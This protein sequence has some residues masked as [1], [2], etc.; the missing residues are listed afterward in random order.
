MEVLRCACVEVFMYTSKMQCRGVSLGWSKPSL[1]V[2][3][4]CCSKP[5]WHAPLPHPTACRHLP[6]PCGN[7]A[8]HS[9]L[10]EKEELNNQAGI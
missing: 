4:Y 1:V 7:Q 9:N 8:S 10:I 5:A 6:S 2:A 3:N